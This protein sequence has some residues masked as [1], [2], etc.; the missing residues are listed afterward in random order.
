MTSRGREFEGIYMTL[1]ALKCRMQ[2]GSRWTVTITHCTFIYLIILTIYC[3]ED[4]R[5]PFEIRLRIPFICTLRL[6]FSFSRS[7][8]IKSDVTT[9]DDAVALQIQ[10][11]FEFN[12][13]WCQM[14]LLWRVVVW[15]HF[16]CLF[17]SALYCVD[18][19]SRN[20]FRLIVAHMFSTLFSTL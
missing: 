15:P 18:V 14:S 20:S 11:E 1:C 7:K 9:I 2:C 6:S 13:F 3:L 16:V 17:V 19:E 4:I 8:G 12:L 5:R 10:F